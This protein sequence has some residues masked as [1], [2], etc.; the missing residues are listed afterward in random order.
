LWFR[1][2]QLAV[3]VPEAEFLSGIDRTIDEV[4]VGLAVLLVIA[5]IAVA[6]GA[7]RFLADPVARVAEDLGHIERFE[8]ERI[9]RRRSRLREIDRLSEAIVRMAAGL[10]DFG[11]FIPTELVRSLVAS[12]MRAEPGGRQRRITVLFADLAGFTALSESLGDRVVP[13]VSGFLDAA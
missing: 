6:M 10:A 12:G 2:W 13:I 3:I 9:P 4:A 1:G 11:K 8:L 7:R 5:G